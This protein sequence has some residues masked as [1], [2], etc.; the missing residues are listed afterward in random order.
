M[1]TGIL[2]TYLHYL[3]L[4]I[5]ALSS[6]VAQATHNRAGEITYTHV[7]GLTYEFVITTYT[8]ESAP[9]DR[10]DLTI[11]FGDNSTSVFYRENGPAG[12]C[13]FP[14]RMGEVLTGDFKKNVYRGQHTFSAQGIYTVSVED[15]NRNSGVD[16][17][18]NSVNV[19]FYIQTTLRINGQLGPNNSAQLLNPPID[20]GCTNKPFYHN[21]SAFDP[22]GDSLG[23]RLINCRGAGRIEI[24]E[25]YD[26]AIVQDP[27]TIDSLIG[28]LKWEV[29][30]S[31]GQYNFAI[32]ITEYRI[33][34][35][36][37]WEFMGSVTRDLQVD[38]DQCNNNP[39]TIDPVGP[40][41]VIAGENVSFTINADDPDGDIIVL[42]GTGGPL[43]VDQAATFIQPVSGPAPISGFFSWNTDCIHVRKLPYRMDFK[44]KD[45]PS[46][47]N[48]PELAAF[49]SV[50]IQI[51][52]PAPENPLATAQGSSIV[53]E[54]DTSICRDAI[55]YKLY[56]RDGLSGYTPD[57]CETGV[58]PSTGYKLI[59]DLSGLGN[60]TYTDS[61]SLKLGN[62][63]CY[64]VV[65]YFEDGS[66]SQ[67]SEEFCASLAENAPIITKVDVL[68]TDIFNGE[69]HIEWIPPREIDSS[70]TPPGYAYALYRGIGLNP[71]SYDSIAYFPNYQDT[72][73]TDTGLN[74]EGQAYSYQVD[75]YY[76]ASSGIAPQKGKTSDPAASPYLQLTADDESVILRL[77]Q[78]VPWVNDTFVIYRESFQGSGQ[79]DSIATSASPTYR[80]TGLVNGETYC[81]LVETKGAYTAGTIFSPLINRSQ[82]GCATPLDTNSPCSPELS[83]IYDCEQSYL[84]FE[85]SL[86]APDCPQD[87][88]YYNIYYKP[89]ELDEFPDEP[90][91]SNITDLFFENFDGELIGC[92]AVTAVDD[93]DGDPGGIANESGFSD[94]ICLDP[95]PI[96]ELPNVFTPNSDNENDFFTIVRDAN[97]NPLAKNIGSFEIVVFNRWGGLVYS[98]NDLDEFVQT[99]WDGKDM[100]SGQDCADGVYFYVCS[101]AVRSVR[102][103]RQMKL[104][105][106]VHL[107]R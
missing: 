51:I 50:E 43:V 42:T 66:L 62:Q 30:Q 37:T 33:G 64:M 8:K 25:T 9:A 21:P 90:L 5:A 75:F 67:A 60:V 104:D 31:A 81:Y 93:A 74:T 103:P 95:C 83:Y 10:C 23:Y 105:G 15:Q 55:G 69:I 35:L 100:S 53:L 1:T 98:S 56:R 41:C 77:Q 84:R 27:I 16:N 24:L 48:E 65:A 20:D 73:F 101:Y 63:Y 17:I 54:W 3:L 26:P 29:P 102:D 34:P 91:I 44:V 97:G 80:D 19:P 2:R 99:G 89:T 22:D 4:A 11:D 76:M 47:A 78:S 45:N 71:S 52:A 94:T 40:F 46:L 92:Y 86:P 58:P 36:G 87:I 72:V 14:A 59:A 68:N 7:S 39:P 32:L 88:A 49:M 38:I 70:L 107:F 57:S 6:S 12:G 61:D 13:P 79:F 96:L 28:E 18:P 85:W 106:S 82:E